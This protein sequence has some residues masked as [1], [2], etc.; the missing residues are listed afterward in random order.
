M[1]D[2]RIKNSVLLLLS[3]V[4]IILVSGCASLNQAECVSANWF[5][6]GYD[7]V[8]QGN[9]SLYVAKHTDACA[10]YGITPDFAQYK[11]GWQQGLTKFCTAQSGWRYA[12]S[13]SYYHNT[14]PQSSEPQFFSGYR[15]GEKINARESTISTA[16]KEIKQLFANIENEKLTEEQRYTRFSERFSLTLE[17]KLMELELSRLKDQAQQS[18]FW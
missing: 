5:D 16:K 10:E 15:L 18:G 14:C 12:R 13:G 3:G 11:L 8:Q 1:S 2:W 17:L 4:G 9:R 7:D 6:L